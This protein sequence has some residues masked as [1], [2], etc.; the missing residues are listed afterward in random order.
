MQKHLPIVRWNYTV[1]WCDMH[2]PSSQSR[3]IS[4]LLAPLWKRIEDIRFF[5]FVV[6]AATADARAIE[7][8]SQ[9]VHC[10]VFNVTLLLV[11]QQASIRLDFQNGY[12]SSTSFI[13]A[14]LENC[15]SLLGVIS[16][17]IDDCLS[18]QYSWNSCETVFDNSCSKLSP[19]SGC[20]KT[21]FATMLHRPLDTFKNRDLVYSENDVPV[22]TRLFGSK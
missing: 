14:S 21:K 7:L 6:F 16:L 22:S 5:W 12:G 13:N 17:R 9:F 2:T 18:A 15:V 19:R 1:E 10:T 20:L 11:L 8:S 3:S 4:S